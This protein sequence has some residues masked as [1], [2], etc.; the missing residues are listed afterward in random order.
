MA[1][2]DIARL[3]AEYETLVAKQAQPDPAATTSA[4]AEAAGLHYVRWEKDGSY[5]KDAHNALVFG[6]NSGGFIT[7]PATSFEFDDDE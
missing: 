7:S 5:W 1:P 4:V 3:N 2:G 6:Q